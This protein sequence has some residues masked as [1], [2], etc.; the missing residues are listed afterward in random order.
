MCSRTDSTFSVGSRESNRG[1]PFRSEKRALQAEHAPRLVGAVAAGHG[2][3]SGPPFAML[4]ALRIQAAEARKVVH[5]AA[6]PVRSS[7]PDGDYAIRSGYTSGAGECNSV[8]PPGTIARDPKK[9]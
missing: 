1:V 4:G 7:N 6:P 3:V 8:R 9:C 5:G 2:Q